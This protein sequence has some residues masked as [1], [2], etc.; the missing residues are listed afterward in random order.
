MRR[1][2]ISISKVVNEV[3]EDSFADTFVDIICKETKRDKNS[4]TINDRRE[5]AEEG[6]ERMLTM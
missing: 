4:L 2:N 3:N 1:L 5:M 6:D